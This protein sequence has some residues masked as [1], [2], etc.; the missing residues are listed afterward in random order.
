LLVL[1]L[2][3]AGLSGCADDSKFA[4]LTVEL[5]SLSSVDPET[6]ENECGL[7]RETELPAEVTCLAFSLCR[8]TDEACEP[9][10]LVR[11]GARGGG[12]RV[13]RVPRSSVVSFDTAAA[14]DGFE[15]TVTAYD[16]DGDVYATATTRGISIGAPV[17]VRLERRQAEPAWSC[18][19]G[20]A[21]GTMQPRALH[22]T[23]SLPNGEVLLF[24][25]VFGDA[26]DSTIL[27]SGTQG[28]TLQPAI[29]VYDAVAQRI[30]P[31]RVAGS[32]DW[33]GRVL[34]GSRLLPGPQ[35]GPYTIAL[36]GG[37]E[38]DS[39]AVL[40][41]DEIQSENAVGSPLVPSPDAAPGPALRLTYDPRA[42]RVTIE[43]LPLG[44]AD[45]VP[46]GF[47]AL[48]EDLD[49]DTTA[50]L[51][52]G[53]GAF[54]G[55]TR[56]P[57]LAPARAVFWVGSSGAIPPSRTST[58]FATPRLGATATAIDDERVLAWGGVIDEMANENARLRAG[59]LLSVT[60]DMAVLRGGVATDCPSAAAAPSPEG[61]PAPTAFHTA[62]RIASGE[63]LVAGGL[64]VSGTTECAGRGVTGLA[65]AAQPLT[66]VS[67][68][69]T[70]AASGVGVAVPST[71]QAPVFHSA[72]ATARGVVL[73][74]GA[75][76]QGL[77]LEG[78]TQVGLVTRSGPGAY[79]FEALP[80]LVTPRFGHAATLLPGERLLVTGGFERIP[81]TGSERRVRA[82]NFAE[83]LPL[84]PRPAP[85]LE[86]SDELLAPGDAGS[87]D[88]G[89]RDAA[90]D[91][92][93]ADASVA[94]A[95]V[96]D[97]GVDDAGP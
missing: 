64:L 97:A 65:P 16:V 17:R 91:A 36:Y 73:V 52:L 11:T 77:R 39:G 82:L 47:V 76:K 5:A 10:G 67:I 33:G 71:F 35:G 13:L 87:G 94:D 14:G 31:V 79:G 9:V 4:T 72:T 6:G 81:S 24:G 57:D 41:L 46:S 66:V 34:F 75:A 23:T 42:R 37:Y 90:T 19:P 12:A 48:S 15:L 63:V 49:G 86:C 30:A 62:T 32:Y 1:A 83:V 18:A 22:A 55:P 21:S 2:V 95:G 85:A 78:L 84:A 92:S 59:E 80:A 43:P 44:D 27:P 89:R 45:A 50:L 51:A 58:P 74:G 88:A 54:E 25:G 53:A 26:I 7:T 56:V 68:D 29:E 38:A 40:F 20:T 8:R 70:G 93:A 60:G 3:S 28:A 96:D 69:S 61:V